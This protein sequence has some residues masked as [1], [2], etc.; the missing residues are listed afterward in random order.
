MAPKGLYSVQKSRSFGGTNNIV[1]E[2]SSSGNS[3]ALSVEQGRKTP[4]FDSLRKKFSRKKTTSTEDD[5]GDQFDGSHGSSFRRKNK[6]P[7]KVGN[8]LKWFKKDSNS[9]NGDFYP[10]HDLPR[11]NHQRS[12]VSSKPKRSCSYD[13]ICS[14]ASAASSFAFVP[15]DAYKVGRFVEPK[16]K[17]AIGIN[18]GQDTYRKRLEQREDDLENNKELS[19]STK[20]NLMSSESPPTLVKKCPAGPQGPLLQSSELHRNDDTNSSSESGGD[21][22]EHRSVSQRASPDHDRSASL[23]RADQQQHRRVS[24]VEKQCIKPGELRGQHLHPSTIKHHLD[25]YDRDHGTLRQ[26][27]SSPPR[28]RRPAANKCGKNSDNLPITPADP[29]KHSASVFHSHSNNPFEEDLNNFDDCHLLNT[30]SPR[31]SVSEDSDSRQQG[32]HIPGKR[33]APEPPVRSLSPGRRGQVTQVTQV[34]GAAGGE[35]HQFVKKKGRAPQPP[36]VRD[37]NTRECESLAAGDCA[38]L[39]RLQVKSVSQSQGWSRNNSEEVSAAMITTSSPPASPPADRRC[40]PCDPCDPPRD[41]VIQDGLLRSSNRDSQQDI[42]SSVEQDSCKVPLSPKPWYKRNIIKDNN[43][44]KQKDK[45]AKSPNLPEVHTSRERIKSSESE[46]VSNIICDKVPETPKSPKQFLRSKIIGSPRAERPQ[47]RPISGLTGISELDR[48]AAEIIRRKNEDEAAKK[49]EEDNKFYESVEHE[50]REAQKAIDNIMDK[51][52]R[53]MVKLDGISKKNDWNAFLQSNKDERQS[54]ECRDVNSNETDKREAK[55][56]DIEEDFQ[57]MG[58]VVSDLNSFLAST[59]KALSSPLNKK[60]SQ[61]SDN[62]TDIKMQQSKVVSSERRA[63]INPDRNKNN[64]LSQP[65]QNPNYF[66]PVSGSASAFKSQ[67]NFPPPPI[68]TAS[69][70]PTTTAT[71]P[72]STEE[73]TWT[74]HRCTLININNKVSCEVCGAARVGDEVISQD[75]LEAESEEAPPKPGNVLNKLLLFSTMDAKS[76]ETPTLQRRKSAE[77]KQLSRTF[78]SSMLPIDENPLQKTLERIAEKQAELAKPADC[79]NNN[80]FTSKDAKVE[81]CNSNSSTSS[82]GN[83]TNKTNIVMQQQKLLEDAVLNQQK[84]QQSEDI[85]NVAEKASTLPFGK[86]VSSNEKNHNYMTN[87]NSSSASNERE[88]IKS[89]SVIIPSQSNKDTDPLPRPEPVPS[90][91]LK[92]SF[93]FNKTP[94]AF[95]SSSTISQPTPKPWTKFNHDHDSGE[96]IKSNIKAAP[97]LE[98]LGSEVTR[99]I[100]APDKIMNVEP[101]KEDKMHQVNNSNYYYLN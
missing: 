53:K 15:V 34:S 2:E 62:K 60:R 82:S 93:D 37:N 38:G 8:I 94:R 12:A 95:L 86:N 52:S 75:D 11:F 58:S 91:S 43:D 80:F 17:I 10:D 56:V 3:T 28:H 6:G 66:P 35:Y 73:S 64:T 76:K 84:Q 45:K 101:K 89:P 32:V 74:C 42:L 50:G 49:R 1:F 78:S 97:R 16:K 92:S 61:Q 29:G 40:D 47:S 65:D 18:C 27:P 39:A 44:K 14:V 30:S 57:H 36:S 83:Q 99:K 59:R 85:L 68:T 98:F 33:R 79:F 72:I 22:L 4:N 21:T 77:I 70:P 55:E 54:D 90:F 26:V 31:T 19:L 23:T 51:V 9:K 46:K 63:E 48:Q 7:S 71:Q 67:S 25:D 87:E 88:I 20:Y 5:E 13:S 81:K 96:N 41:W 69:P 24:S 100:S